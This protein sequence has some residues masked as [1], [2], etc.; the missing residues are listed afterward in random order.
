M[1]LFI[2][3]CQKVE[4]SCAFCQGHHALKKDQFHTLPRVLVLHLKRFGG[5]GGA[6][7]L[8]TPLFIPPNLS[9]STLCGDTVPPLHSIVP[10]DFTNQ[11]AST[12]E[13]ACNS[14]ST[15][16]EP[17]DVQQTATV[18]NNRMES[19]S[20]YQLTGIVSHIGESLNNGHYISEILGAGGQWLYCNDRDVSPS[21]ED[22]VLSNSNK[23]GYMLF[24]VY[25][26][27]NHVISKGPLY[28]P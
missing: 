11:D 16:H 23:N 8:E 9:L 28:A 20:Y 21:N 2:T 18:N 14:D 13:K 3:Q 6:E 7:K 4:F 24:Y 17:G 12:S 22:T 25:R 10:E 27:N 15:E 19:T 26:A 1:L 5:P